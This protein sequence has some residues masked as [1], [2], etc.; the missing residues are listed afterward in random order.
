MSKSEPKLLL[1]DIL[2]SIIKINSYTFE[3][4]YESV[5]DGFKNT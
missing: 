4:S 3:H 1:G 2:D 5:F